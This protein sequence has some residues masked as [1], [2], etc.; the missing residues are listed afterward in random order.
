MPL[1]PTEKYSLENRSRLMPF[2]FVHNFENTEE[3]GMF[4]NNLPT[5]FY[6]IDCVI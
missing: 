5:Y 4:K 6:R 1:A 3:T 2:F